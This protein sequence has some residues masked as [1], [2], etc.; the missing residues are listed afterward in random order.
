MIKDQR[1]E[2]AHQTVTQAAFVLQEADQRI[3]EIRQQH[4]HSKGQ[5][6]AAQEID[7]IDDHC[8]NQEG[9]QGADEAIE[10]D[11]LRDRHS[12]GFSIN[13]RIKTVV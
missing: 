4:S 3:G 9:D 13:P 6:N 5:Q 12:Y 10:G 8:H 11:G 7:Y 1:N 2:D